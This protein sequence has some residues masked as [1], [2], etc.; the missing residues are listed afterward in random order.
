MTNLRF[1]LTL[2]IVLS[3]GWFSTPSQ[4][5][6]VRTIFV[7]GDSLTGVPNSWAEQLN[8]R[9]LWVRNFAIPGLQ[10]RDFEIPPYFTCTNNR[11]LWAD[12]V[13][14]AL[15]TNDAIFG[16]VGAYTRS[17]WNAIAALKARNCTKIYIVQAVDFTDREPIAKR[18][19]KI[20]DVAHQAAMLHDLIIVDM[21][22]DRNELV[23]GIHQNDYLHDLQAEQWRR[24]FEEEACYYDC[25]L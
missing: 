19:R 20:R 21:T 23:D 14:I 2:L 24:I 10:M 7:F 18:I 12:E 15:G 3:V 5:D 6:P 9:D 13:V 22:Y 4:A 17:L 16:N 11:N 25:E 8:T 1:A